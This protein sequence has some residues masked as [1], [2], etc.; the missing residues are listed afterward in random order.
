MSPTKPTVH[1]KLDQRGAL[2]RFSASAMAVSMLVLGA[3]EN[4][5][6]NLPIKKAS[7]ALTAENNVANVTKNLTDSMGFLAESDS[8]AG[9]LNSLRDC[10][11]YTPPEQSRPCTVKGDPSCDEPPPEAEP[12]EPSNECDTA[13][14]KQDLAEM[15][16][17]MQGEIDEFV[18]RLKAEIF[19]PD[20]VESETDTEIV[21]KVPLTVACEDASD[22]EC[23]DDWRR[24]QYRLRVTSPSEGDLD[25]GLLMTA[26]RLETVTFK[27]YDN[28]IGFSVDLGA[29]VEAGRTIDPQE[30]D[31]VTRAAGVVEMSLVKNDARDFSLVGEIKKAID[32][33]VTETD[34]DTLETETFA[35]KVDE[36]DRTYELRLDGNQ[37]KVSA[38]VNVGLFQVS[39]PLGG[40]G[41]MFGTGDAM[42]TADLFNFVLGGVNGTLTLDD[43]SDLIKFTKLGLGDKST[44]I[45]VNGKEVFTLDVNKNSGRRFDMTASMTNTDTPIM[46]FD[47]GLSVAMKFDFSSI[48]N[49]F[50]SMPAWLNNDTV[51]I[52]LTGNKPTIRSRLESLEVVSGTLRYSSNAVPSENV[53]VNAGQ[54]LLSETPYD[55]DPPPAHDILSR[56]SAGACE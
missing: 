43:A 15:K 22:T 46:T 36:S 16:D 6:T 52:E 24:G 33:A 12:V 37:K 19:T 34:E 25:V 51:A 18:A 47:P 28:K 54:C 48:R 55:T 14:M 21:Y 35:F 50:E 26:N 39:A 38:H 3:C 8:L 45:S 31:D 13:S 9:S 4:E 7:I 27:L 32:I 40:L 42:K 56:L 11:Q 10:E 53:T 17:E 1:T 20:N 44:T 5:A 30:F 41:G 29:F 49:R 2:R 23:T